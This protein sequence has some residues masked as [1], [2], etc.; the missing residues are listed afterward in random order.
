MILWLQKDSKYQWRFK[1]KQI[2]KYVKSLSFDMCDPENA[3]EGEN[4]YEFE[5]PQPQVPD[6]ELMDF[7]NDEVE[8]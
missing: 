8:Q 2:K 1:N 5:Q 6:T 3:E 4:E 7:K